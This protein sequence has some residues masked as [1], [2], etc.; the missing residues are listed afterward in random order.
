MAFNVKTRAADL[1][2][3]KLCERPD[4]ERHGISGFWRADLRRVR[5][6]KETRIRVASI[7]DGRFVEFHRGHRV[8]PLDRR[9]APERPESP[10]LQ[11]WAA[12]TD[13][14][15]MPVVKVTQ[16]TLDA[17]ADILN[18]KVQVTVEG[19]DGSRAVFSG[20]LTGV[21]GEA[22]AGIELD[23]HKFRLPLSAITEV[24]VHKRA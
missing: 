14:P 8:S 13:E 20:V 6:R 1:M 15:C 22:P 19:E 9:R 16:L 21:D 12:R 17:L 24:G 23:H 18:K 2:W 11:P 5:V 4:G 3:L 10:A 7:A